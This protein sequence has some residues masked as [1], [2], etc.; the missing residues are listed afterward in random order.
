[1]RRCLL[2]WLAPLLIAG[3]CLLPAAVQAQDTGI[4]RGVKT[5]TTTASDAPERTAGP[6]YVVGV[7]LAI[8]VLLPVC[9]PSR[10][11]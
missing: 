7:L 9:I 6:A 8:I 11:A 1:M 5:E 4:E 10:K 2:R 3:S